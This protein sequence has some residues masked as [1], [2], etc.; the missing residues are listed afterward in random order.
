[1]VRFIAGLERLFSA[2][3]AL[4]VRSIAAVVAKDKRRG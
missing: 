4:A 1:M 3:K 2:K